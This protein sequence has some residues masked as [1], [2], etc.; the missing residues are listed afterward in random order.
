MSADQTRTAHT[1]IEQADEAFQRGDFAA[2]GRL[3]RQATQADS[4]AEA[5][6]ID[7]IAYCRLD[8][9]VRHL[10]HPAPNAPPP[11]ELEREVTDCVRR[12]PRLD[13]F[14]QK[15]LARIRQQ[16]GTPGPAPAAEPAVD[17]WTLI[18][19]AN[20]RICH[21]GTP[22]LADQVGKQAEQTRQAMFARWF[23]SGGSA[24]SPRCT[25]FLHPDA[26]AYAQA[27]GKPAAAPGHGTINL[28]GAQVVG[29]RLDLHCDDLNLLP[30]TLPHETTHVVLA[31]LFG[32]QEL[33]RWADEGMAELSESAAQQ[34]RYRQALVRCARENRLVPLHELVQRPDLPADPAAATAVCVQGFALV[35]MLTREKGP[36]AF[37]LFLREAPRRGF[38]AALQ[39]HYGYRDLRELQE[40]WDRQYL[41]SGAGAE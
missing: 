7:Q 3:Y 19:T 31:D 33:P 4:T 6:H 32:D 13:E 26:T 2:A 8:E 29:R 40:R 34:Q 23:G 10:N 39:R 15:V 27:T 20:F 28:N 12:S 35:E 22:E 16:K 14:G 38:A 30:A 36:Q 24:W 11:A 25:I 1:L 21:R 5:G 17:G 37:A 9:V 41:P 18:E